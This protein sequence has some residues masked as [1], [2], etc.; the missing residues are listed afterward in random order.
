MLCG[1]VLLLWPMDVSEYKRID[2]SGEMVDRSGNLLYPFLN[3]EEQW[4]FERNLEEISPRLIQATIAAEDQRFYIHPGV[5]PIAVL[6]AVWQNLCGAR[7]VSG[8]STLTMQAVKLTHPYRRSY[9]DKIL[10]AIEA[11]RLQCRLSK[12]E[13]LWIYLNR[14][15]YGQNLVGCEAASW[16]YFGKPASELTISEAALLAALPKSPSQTMPLRHPRRARARRDYVLRRMHEEGFITLQELHDAIIQPLSTHYHA[17]PMYAPHLAIQIKRKP[18]E[19]KKI[20]TTL[21]LTTQKNIERLAKEATQHFKGEIGN[22]AAIVVDVSTANIIARV[23]SADFLHTPGG[24]Q[25]DLCQAQ[26]SPGSALKPF[27]YALAMQQNQLYACETL[28]DES[29]DQGLYNPENFDLKYR[30]LISADYALRHSLNVPAVT[31]LERIGVEGFYNYL[32]EIGLSTLTR[33]PEYYGLGLTLGNAEVKLEEVAAAYCALANLGTY[34][35]LRVFENQPP[36][37]EQQILTRGTGLKVYEML[38]QP[39]PQELL[40]E[41]VEVIN[42]PERVC[43]KTGTSQ[44]RRDAWA[45]VFNRHYVVGVWMGNNDSHPSRQLVGANSALPLAAKIFRALPKRND[46]SWPEVKQDLKPVSICAVSG[47]PTSE[48]CKQKR[49]VYLPR[50]QFL[51]RICDM[52]YPSTATDETESNTGGVI[53]RWPS[54]PHGWDLANITTAYIQRESHDSTSQKAVFKDLRILEPSNHAEFVLTQQSDGD[55]IRVRT[56]LDT[57]ERLHW[58]DSES[59]LGT[60]TP[61]SPIHLQLKPGSHRLTCMT[62][63]GMVDTIIYIVH[64]PATSILN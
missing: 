17:F 62:D 22:A 4:C 10:Q 18:S 24:G 29:W 49:T 5:D 9:L 15:P 52:H 14:A 57:K 33:N 47:L 39:F 1:A 30:G 34:R 27:L 42:A 59:Y 2:F 8:A 51:H 13:I 48:W 31:L 32:K 26:R 28:L 19:A 60:S 6:R 63:E 50:E 25:V 54:T 3:Q 35:N 23:G 58:Y 12:D 37:H 7:V 36:S 56:S 40:Q 21:D 41:N 44:G 38:E 16:R 55:I 45:F 43:W 61:E 64:E 46:P 53:Q 20:Q 11:V